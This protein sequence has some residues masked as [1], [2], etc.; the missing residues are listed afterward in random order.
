LAAAGRLDEAIPACRLILSAEPHNANFRFLLADSLRQVGKTDEA[1]EQYKLG[2]ADDPDS[3]T[4]HNIV[5]GLLARR[6]RLDDAIPH[7]ESA[8]RLAPTMPDPKYN[9]GMIEYARGN[10]QQ[11]EHFWR[12]AIE[13]RP[14][15]VEYLR[16]LAWVLATSSDPAARNGREAV[17]IAERAVTASHEP[18]ANIVGTLAAAYAEAGDF[19]KA[20]SNAEKALDLAQRKGDSQLAGQLSQRLNDYR[21]GKPFHETSRRKPTEDH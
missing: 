1:V 11:A 13:L 17:E 10:D 4:A 20:V 19:A 16:P 7:F 9:L 14:D 6:G 15:S 18:N 21:S 2:I 12:A 3:A 5:G 8:A